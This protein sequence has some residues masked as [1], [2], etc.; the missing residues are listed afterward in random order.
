MEVLQNKPV[1][2]VVGLDVWFHR[3]KVRAVRLVESSSRASQVRS[4]VALEISVIQMVNTCGWRMRLMAPVCFS[5]ETF[6]QQSALVL[7]MQ[8]SGCSAPG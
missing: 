8:L 1:E 3:I 4:A 7:Q 6:K 2:L 5:A